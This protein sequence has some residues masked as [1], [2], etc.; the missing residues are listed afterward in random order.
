MPRS[1][2]DRFCLFVA[3]ALQMFAQQERIERGDLVQLLDQFQIG[4][5]VLFAGVRAERAIRSG[6]SKRSYS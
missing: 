3:G 2:F 5:E 1:R 6:P 4:L